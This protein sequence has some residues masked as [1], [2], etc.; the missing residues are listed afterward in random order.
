[1]E[2][3][4]WLKNFADSGTA[5]R[6][7]KTVYAGY[8][9]EIERLVGMQKFNPKYATIDDAL[10]DFRSRVGFSGKEVK[11]MY[12]AVMK[13][14]AEKEVGFYVTEKDIEKTAKFSE[15]DAIANEM[16]NTPE[17]KEKIKK[18]L[19]KEKMNKLDQDAEIARSLSTDPGQGGLGNGGQGSP[20][21]AAPKGAPNM[22]TMHNLLIEKFG[23]EEPTGWPGEWP[24][25]VPEEP[26]EE[27]FDNA[28]RY[29]GVNF[30]GN[31]PKVS[32]YVVRSIIATSK[33][34]RDAL[35]RDIKKS[36]IASTGK[37]LG[38]RFEQFYKEQEPLEEEVLFQ[39]ILN[40]LDRLIM[41]ETF[42]GVKDKQ[43]A[44]A[45]MDQLFDFYKSDPEGQGLLRQVFEKINTIYTKVDITDEEKAQLRNEIDD[46]YHEM[47][48]H[49]RIIAEE[50]HG[51]IDVPYHGDKGRK[52][53]R[54]PSPKKYFKE[55]PK[56]QRIEVLKL[57]MS[58]LHLDDMIHHTGF[59]K[60]KDYGQVSNLV[61][62]YN[63]TDNYPYLDSDG[64][65]TYDETNT[66]NPNFGNVIDFSKYPI[67]GDIKAKRD[68]LKYQIFGEIK[69][70]V[71][72]DQ[73]LLIDKEGKKLPEGT[74]VSMKAIPE[75]VNKP[76]RFL[77][78]QQ[79]EAKEDSGR[80]TK[81]R[82]GVF[83]TMREIPK[84]SF[85]EVKGLSQRAQEVLPDE[86]YFDSQGRVF[87]N[88]DKL[89]ETNVENFNEGN[90]GLTLEEIDDALMQDTEIPITEEEEFAVAAGLSEKLK[91]VAQKIDN[92]D[93]KQEAK[94]LYEIS[95]VLKGNSNE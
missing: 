13:K 93:T 52:G 64:L 23:K 73:P 50:F 49:N 45:L 72:F 92:G 62:E 53:K 55:L 58:Q 1:M 54:V 39:N 41:S 81:D 57:F 68:I 83:K 37:L 9:E 10:E 40:Q 11:A 4:P 33:A 94:G 19:E 59:K 79:E 65:P 38:E 12:L 91:V 26:T 44:M 46:L 60:V 15:N 85:I 34:M 21:G 2:L 80:Q 29:V 84:I 66:A 14:K 3:S 42:G 69:D 17:E 63:P 43:K 25:R 87:D 48:E 56:D 7:N 76:W 47:A 90:I 24:G 86:F 16:G 28:T 35:Y 74:S 22:G 67:V 6:I 88:E 31:I 5:A 32:V 75:F 71:M 8:L 82:G 18:K 61:L 78:E 51:I 36:I 77:T 89:I 30:K 70:A 95:T 20:G 27:D